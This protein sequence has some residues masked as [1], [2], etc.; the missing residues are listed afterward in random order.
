MH[1]STIDRTNTTNRMYNR[2]IQSGRNGCWGN[3]Y[4]GIRWESTVGRIHD[5]V[6]NVSTGSDGLMLH[7][8]TLS[9]IRGALLS[10][11]NGSVAWSLLE[12]LR[13]ESCRG[14]AQRDR[15]VRRLIFWERNHKRHCVLFSPGRKPDLLCARW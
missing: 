7:R 6:W 13:R 12:L 3:M 4:I 5:P 1:K 8:S 9:K 10:W 11:R 15:N 14:V 2:S